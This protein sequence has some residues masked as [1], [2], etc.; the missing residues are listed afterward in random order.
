[1]KFAQVQQG[2]SHVVKVLKPLT[3]IN[4][5]KECAAQRMISWK[6]HLPGIN[7]GVYYPVEYQHLLDNHQY[8]ILLT[9]GSF[10]QF[11]YEFGA[12]AKL[13]LGK[14]AYYPHPCPTIGSHESLFEAAEAALDAEDTDLSEHLFNRLDLLEKGGTTITNTSHIRFDY[15][16]GVVTHEAAHL[17]LGAIQDF[18]VP[19]TFYPLP[20][21]FVELV[22]SLLNGFGAISAQH[23]GHA[24]NNCLQLDMSQRI[25][26]LRSR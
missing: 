17:Q 26:T 10:F 24:R 19:S 15:D 1:M 7:Q 2:M 5:I 6:Q 4:L 12:D 18:R 21:A 14:L 22:A 16:Q 25:I 9:D 13:R 11:Y 23:I 20:V 3:Q 8:S